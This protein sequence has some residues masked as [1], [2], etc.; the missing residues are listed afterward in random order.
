VLCGGLFISRNKMYQTKLKNGTD[1]IIRRRKISKC[2]DTFS[3]A[4]DYYQESSTAFNG[5]QTLDSK[6]LNESEGKT[7]D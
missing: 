3:L 2:Y 4:I 1:W 6:K 5:A 7:L